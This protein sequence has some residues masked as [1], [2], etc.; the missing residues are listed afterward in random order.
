MFTDYEDRMGF[1]SD[2][3]ALIEADGEI[4]Y[5]NLIPEADYKKM[6]KFVLM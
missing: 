4:I 5:K 3:G 2:N 6:I 1:I